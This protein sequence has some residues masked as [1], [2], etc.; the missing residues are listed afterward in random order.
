MKFRKPLFV[1]F[2]GDSVVGTELIA[3]VDWDYNSQE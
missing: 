1:L 3:S 2:P